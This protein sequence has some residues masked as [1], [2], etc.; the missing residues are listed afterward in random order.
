MYARGSLPKPLYNLLQLL[1][2]QGCPEHRSLPAQF[3][4]GALA[5]SKH[6]TAPSFPSAPIRH[7]LR[8]KVFTLGSCFLFGLDR[9]KELN[10]SFESKG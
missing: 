9:S 10:L 1:S 5:S 8:N 6:T 7:F 4:L 2:G 3:L